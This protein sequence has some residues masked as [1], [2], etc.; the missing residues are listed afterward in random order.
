M[1]LD[2]GVAV[3]GEGTKVIRLADE[4]ARIDALESRVELNVAIIKA[5]LRELGGKVV[6]PKRYADAIH[7]FNES[8]TQVA[9]AA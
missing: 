5:I 3:M 7:E 8:A 1:L 4:M 2:E 9:E 6:L